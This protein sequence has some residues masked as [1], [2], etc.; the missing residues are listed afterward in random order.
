MKKNF[1][2]LLVSTVLLSVPLFAEMNFLNLGQEAVAPG[3]F[4][5]ATEKLVTISQP[6]LVETVGKSG[7]TI[8]GYVPAG[9]ELVCVPTEKGLRAVRIYYCG[10]PVLNSIVFPITDQQQSTGGVL[11]RYEEVSPCSQSPQAQA[12]VSQSAN[13][14]QRI[15]SSVLSSVE[16]GA[17][18]YAAGEAL[19]KHSP[20]AAAAW[21]TEAVGN[22][23]EYNDPLAAIITVAAGV[24]GYNA[25]E[26]HHRRDRCNH[27]YN[28][29]GYRD[30]D[31][32]DRDYRDHRYDRH[33]D[34][35]RNYNHRND[36][37]PNF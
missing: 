19:K 12:A 17:K 30:R 6:L 9:T 27:Y 4:D 8:K 3:R 22:A 28:N 18:G 36:F 23:I 35:G 2:I 37:W 26:D 25:T 5:S 15:L 21:G 24:W 7:K 29:R 13:T 14:Q 11:C 33:D 1:L 31:Y 20:G 16:A 10:N 34:Y 32:R